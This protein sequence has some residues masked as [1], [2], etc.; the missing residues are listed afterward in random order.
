MTDSFPSQPQPHRTGYFCHRAS[1][2]DACN[3][4]VVVLALPRVAHSRCQI[5]SDPPPVLHDAAAAGFEKH[6][7]GAGRTEAVGSLD[8]PDLLLVR[9]EVCRNKNTALARRALL[10][11]AARKTMTAEGVRGPMFMHISRARLAAQRLPSKA[12]AKAFLTQYTAHISI[13][14]GSSRIQAESKIAVRYL[15]Y[16]TA[17]CHKTLARRP[18]PSPTVDLTTIFAH[19]PPSTKA[20][21]PADT[22]QHLLISVAELGGP[23][24]LCPEPCLL[25]QP[26]P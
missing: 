4:A 17:A 26:V 13:V 20:A 2:R 8:Q 11:D 18:K 15:G 9:C 25:L 1:F 14:A 19:P 10:S 22:P 12:D 6:D 7:P 3:D 24:T 21:T 23:V 5:S 16:S